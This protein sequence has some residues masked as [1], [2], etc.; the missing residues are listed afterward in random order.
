MTTE[1][2][3]SSER[4]H[5][6]IRRVRRPRD[7]RCGT[8]LHRRIYLLPSSLTIGNIFFGFYSI[9]TVIN[10]FG[11]DSHY[12]LT[13]AAM[14]LIASA[15]LDMI[16]GKVARLTGTTSDFGVQLDSLSDVIS[17]G[18]APGILAYAWAL[19][20][21]QR[22]GW[23]PAFLFLICGTIRLARFNVQTGHCDPHYFTGLPIPAAAMVIVSMVLLNPKLPYKSTIAYLVILLV[24][25][26]SFLMVSTF[27]YRSFKEKD[28][29]LLK[30]VRT[31][32]GL[33]IIFVIIMHNP[34]LMF[35]LLSF[36]YAFSGPLGKLLPKRHPLVDKL[37]DDLLDNLTE[38]ISE[39][40]DEECAEPNGGV[41]PAGPERKE[42][43]KAGE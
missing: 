24:Y 40:D 7:P 35:F 34:R 38:R 6:R 8:P 15:F 31:L 16:D 2:T 32:V 1:K 17:F 27:K 21:H 14:A 23:L 11:A 3:E 28:F 39:V 5:M 22:L 25:I 37:T 10:N 13:R 30:P 36:A 26:L 41:T 18:I 20:P 29:K 43:D 42:P 33:V 19:H 12:Y 4:R 9:M